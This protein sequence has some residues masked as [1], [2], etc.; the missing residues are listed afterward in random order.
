M[1]VGQIARRYAGALADVVERS[2]EAEAVRTELKIWEDLMRGG[3]DLRG[4]DN[5]TIDHKLKQNVL[6]QLIARTRPARTT[7]NFLRVLVKNRRLRYL[8]D[9]NAQFDKELDEREGTTHVTV[10]SSRELTEGE[11]AELV[12]NLAA[13][14]G[15]KIRPE[16]EIDAG[17]IG[18]VVAQIGSTVYDGSVRTKLR[19]LREQL[20]NG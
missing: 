6:E 13:V 2:G 7:A 15:K 19:N 17:L 12:R 20:V 16:Y 11:R 10:M 5:P 4:L 1:S 18:G 3:S 8:P 14:T 9:I